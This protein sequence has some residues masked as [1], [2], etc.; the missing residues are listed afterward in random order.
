MTLF[1]D[2]GVDPRDER[3]V[4][5]D[6]LRWYGAIGDAAVGNSPGF[7]VRKASL[8]I[9]LAEVAHVS[10]AE[11]DALYVAGV[12]H[13]VGAIGSPAYRKGETLSDRIAAHERW[14]LPARGARF[15]TSLAALAPET[16][17]MIRWQSEAWDGTGFPDQ[18]RWHGI[19]PAAQ[20][21]ALADFFLRTNDP[22]DALGTIGMQSGR[23]FGPD[24]VRIFTMWFHLSGGEV[25][26]LPFPIEA[27]PANVNAVDV[28]DA[29]ADAID[30][31]NAV[32]GRWR[33]L[34]RLCLG[35]AGA[36]Q[37]DAAS[38][39]RLSLACRMFGAGEVTQA[40]TEDAQF[41]PLARL[42]I[43]LRARNAAAAASLAEPLET[44][45]HVSAIIAAR[46]EWFDGT[47]KPK[48]LKHGEIPRESAILAT[49]IA[50]ERLD[51]G[52][53]LEDA[54]GTQFDPVVVRALIETAK[55]RA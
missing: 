52:E 31:H 22:E 26:T 39:A 15:A 11:R 44:L 14:D 38:K 10:S 48:Q 50:Y 13:A 53:R 9:A 2:S 4:L 16:P 28:L 27:L 47:G 5:A 3:S 45:R 19:P 34:E 6:V 30:A 29:M 54:A 41:D 36:L 35:A 55:A 33:R 23:A 37:A 21:L 8:A 12:L 1:Q 42:G 46:S 18:L 32:N 43:D 25:E 17:D 24:F 7:G 40:H 49:A 51:R 20:C